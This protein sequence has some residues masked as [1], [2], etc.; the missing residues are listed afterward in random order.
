MTSTLQA[1]QSLQF[2]EVRQRMF[3]APCLVAYSWLLHCGQ[4]WLLADDLFYQR[5]GDRRGRTHRVKKIY[6]PSQLRPLKTGQI[7]FFV[8]GLY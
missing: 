3:L 6:Q 7:L 1:R 5:E 4:R 2:V 8:V